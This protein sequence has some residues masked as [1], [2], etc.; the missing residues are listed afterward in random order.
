MLNRWASL[1]MSTCVLKALPG[2]LDIERHSPSIHYFSPSLAITVYRR[3]GAY[4][5]ETAFPEPY[6]LQKRSLFAENK[7]CGK[8]GL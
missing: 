4:P 6:P 3:K 2:K 5:F 7:T 8:E 1:A